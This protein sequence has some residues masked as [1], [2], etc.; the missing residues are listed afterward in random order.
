MPPPPARKPPMPAGISK[1]P[2]PPVAGHTPAAFTMDAVDTT[3]IGKTIVLYGKSGV[4]KTTLASM[5]PG[6]RFIPLD[7]GSK[8]ILHPKTGAK[9]IGLKR[10]DKLAL[11]FQDVR[12]AL[13]NPDLWPAGSTCVIDTGTKLETIAEKYVFENVPGPAS[14]PKCK[15]IED[16]GYGKGYKHLLDAMRMI[17]GDLDRLKSTGVNIIILAQ[18]AQAT[19]S[20]LAGLD[21][22]EDGP[23]FSNAKAYPVRTEVVEW[24]DHVLRLGHGDVLVA[25]ASK[26]AKRGKASGSTDRIIYTQPEVYYLAKSRPINGKHLP[27]LISFDAPDND[28]LWDMVFNGN[29]PEA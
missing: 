24:A 12:D 4:G 10:Q 22:L 28:S 29:I 2:P 14:C 26:E 20:N 7:D 15:N 6:A 19:V 3:G 11:T 1:P 21:Y 9:L 25:T 18:L 5:A 23:K 27:P 17:L 16:Y 8:D 13:H